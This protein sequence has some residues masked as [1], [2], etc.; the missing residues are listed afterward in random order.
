MQ[1]F[2]SRNKTTVVYIVAGLFVLLN[3]VLIYMEF[4]Y[5]GLLSM[6][7]GVAFV[8]FTRLDILVYLI[9]VL[10]PVSIPLRELVKG[11]EN[12]I[13][14]PSEPLI[15][16]ALLVFIFKLLYEKSFDKRV[17]K[18]PI[19]IAISANL[20][21]IFLTSITSTMPLVSFKFLLSRIWFLVVYF[22]LMSQIFRNYKNFDRYLWM[23]IIP[24]LIVIFYAITRQFIYGIGNQKAANFVPN[25]FYGDHTAY[26]A[27]LAMIYPVVIY[28]FIQKNK[29]LLY[30]VLTFLL[31]ILFSAAIILSYTRAT[32]LSIA[33]TFVVFL[34]VIFKIRFRYLFLSAILVLGIIISSW[35]TIM[36]KLEKNRTDSS[37]Y[38]VEH[39]QSM[40]NVTTDASNLERINRWSSALKMFKE[41]PI[42]GWGPGTYKFKYAPFQMSYQKTIISTNAGVLGNAHSEYIGPLSEMGFMGTI[43]FLLIIAL[44][45]YYSI[46]LYYRTKDQKTKQ[47]V[48]ALIMG[49]VSYY[50]HGILN[51]FL[52]T[53]K[54]SCLFWGFTAIFISIEIYH[55]EKITGPENSESVK[56]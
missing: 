10:T 45:L 53:D 38:L 1:N 28:F 24:L 20:I 11:Y 3:S 14:L 41:K 7:L 54:A 2:I 52:D 8:A 30:R 12:D 33:V 37:D 35:S 29:T 32:W 47:L 17:L 50:I 46:R 39:V 16:V 26:G 19:T 49:L 40:S 56:S 51:N 21:W 22:F 23:F 4:F 36:M 9:V 13:I 55:K 18:H 43:T 15:L 44:T 42:L 5:L 6:A 27:S 31:L 48:L 25:P 34:I